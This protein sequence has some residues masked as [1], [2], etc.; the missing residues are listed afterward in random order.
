LLCGGGVDVI[1]LHREHVGV[2]LGIQQML[3]Q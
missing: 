1:G 3:Q 2:H